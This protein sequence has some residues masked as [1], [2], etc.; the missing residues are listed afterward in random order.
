MQKD[1][2]TFLGRPSNIEFNY[3]AEGNRYGRMKYRRCGRSGLVLPLLSL[4]LWQNFGEEAPYSAAKGMLLKAFDAGI[5]HFDL[6]NNYGNPPGSAERTLGRVLRE[7]LEPYRDQLIVSTKAGYDMWPGPY[8]EG[9]SRKYLVASLDQSLA[10]LGLDYVDIFY[11]HR[12]DKETPLEETMEALDL[13]LRRGKA[14]YVGISSYGPAETA[15]AVEILKALGSRCVIH[16][17]S[18]SL[19]NRWIEREGLLDILREQGMGCITF[20][21]LEQGLLTGKYL[22][23]VPEDSR[24]ARPGSL[25]TTE[26]LRSEITASIKALNDIA[27]RRGQTLAQM[28]LAWVLRDEVV[29]S[30]IIGVR[31]PEQLEQNLG[32]LGNLD[33]SPM[34]LAEIDHWAKDFDVTLWPANC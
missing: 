30:T 28:A 17:P 22:G 8:G 5:T 11:S 24:I 3:V 7:E 13:I 1:E 32:V 18:Y 34:E 14:L 29:C 2:S 27:S 31:T 12:L 16:Q 6:A 9:G 4:G 25:L 26:V 33:F 15:R 21:A 23:G 19:F 20:T 10:R